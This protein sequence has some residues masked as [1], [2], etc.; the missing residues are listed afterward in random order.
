MLQNK[1]I[2]SL[3]KSHTKQIQPSKSNEYTNKSKFNDN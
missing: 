2:N 1:L 3:L